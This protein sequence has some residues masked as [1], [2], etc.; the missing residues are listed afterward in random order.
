[1][2]ND[3]M[4]GDELDPAAIGRDAAL[5]QALSRR[6]SPPSDVE[7]DAVV[8]SLTAWVGWVD[9][10][11]GIDVALPMP[12]PRSLGR[13]RVVSL[14]AQRQRR[15]ALVVGATIAALVVSSGA[16]AAVTGDPFAVARA[17]LSVIEQFSPFGDGSSNARESLPDPASPTADVNKL[18]ADAQRAVAAGEFDEAERLLDQAGAALGEGANPGQEHRIDR[19]LDLVA[20]GPDHG[21]GQGQA[22]GHDGTA[23]QG[24]G[25]S[26]RPGGRADHAHGQI[27]DPDHG[28]GKGRSNGHG[29]GKGQ[30]VEQGAGT[31][32]GGQGSPGDPS[33][34]GDP[35]GPGSRGSGGPSPS[36]GPGSGSGSSTG[37]SRGGKGGGHGSD[38][39]SAATAPSSSGSGG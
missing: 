20:N 14:D 22:H 27:A 25:T 34:S 16:A 37:G 8:E 13:D 36:S 5:I 39:V 26:N 31:S 9:T 23:D 11:A 6:T 29:Q 35:D 12:T 18:L 17:P 3:V 33:D 7:R 30:D 1:M 10:P 15:A 28:S 4:S 2:S 21:P 32:T 24:K 38:D 19:L